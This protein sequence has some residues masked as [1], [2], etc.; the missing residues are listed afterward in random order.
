MASHL[1][2]AVLGLLFAWSIASGAG[3][4]HAQE[5]KKT[6]AIQIGAAV[7]TASGGQE[8]DF[9]RAVKQLDKF[10]ERRNLP[11]L[12]RSVALELRGQYRFAIDQDASALADDLIMALRLEADKQSSRARRLAETAGNALRQANRLDDALQ[13]AD[14]FP[15]SF[16]RGDKGARLFKAEVLAFRGD[17]SVALSVLGAENSESDTVREMKLRYALLLTDGQYAAAERALDGFDREP[18]YAPAIEEERRILQRLQ[19]GSASQQERMSAGLEFA[20]LIDDLLQEAE[21]IERVNPKGFERCI[22]QSVDKAPV[23]VELIYDIDRAGNVSNVRVANSDN[24]CYNKSA[25]EA[26]SQ[27]KFRPARSN[28]RNVE[29]KDMKVTIVFQIAS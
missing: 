15:T 13:F 9:R 5:L 3:G 20:Q 17:V 21:P 19:A 28:S 4:A 22:R 6:S 1:T 26:A 16:P 24:P 27:W 7:R 29:R 11:D 23:R 8:T 10:L 12:D 2:R 18:Y 14:E 25:V